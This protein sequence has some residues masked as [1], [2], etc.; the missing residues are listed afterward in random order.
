MVG[1]R[2]PEP[3]LSSPIIPDPGGHQHSE[4]DP[5]PAYSSLCQGV[6]AGEPSD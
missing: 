3:G 2:G 4:L 6:A 1:E 5:L